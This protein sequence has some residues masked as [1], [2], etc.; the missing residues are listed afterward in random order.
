[1]KT[2]KTRHTWLT[3]SCIVLSSTVVNMYD[4]VGFRDQS[5]KTEKAWHIDMY[6]TSYGKMGYKH[7]AL[8]ILNLGK[9]PPKS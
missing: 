8:N 9:K 2:N 7:F 5:A 6:K 3:R 1:M 4:I